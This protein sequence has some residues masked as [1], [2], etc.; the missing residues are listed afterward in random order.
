MYEYNKIHY[1]NLETN[2]LWISFHYFS[3]NF[4]FIKQQKQ[5]SNNKTRNIFNVFVAKE[6]LLKL[7][8]AFRLNNGK[9]KLEKALNVGV[10]SRA[11]CAKK[12]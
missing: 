8:S 4:N 2:V 11:F 3:F 1:K 7:K 12:H 6:M 10:I 9:K 5:R